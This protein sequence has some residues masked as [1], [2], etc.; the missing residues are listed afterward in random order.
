MNICNK[1]KLESLDDFLEA[2]R[3]LDELWDKQDDRVTKLIHLLTEYEE[4]NQ[5]QVGQINGN[6]AEIP[7]E[8]SNFDDFAIY[9]QDEEY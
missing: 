4:E 5:D 9:G 3:A 2:E 1:K 6:D 7:L 8:D